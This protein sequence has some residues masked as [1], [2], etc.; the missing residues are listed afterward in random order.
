MIGFYPLSSVSYPLPSVSCLP[1][2]CRGESPEATTGHLNPEIKKHLDLNRLNLY[3]LNI[4][5]LLLNI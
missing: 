4:D 2:P 1:R 3:Y 5:C